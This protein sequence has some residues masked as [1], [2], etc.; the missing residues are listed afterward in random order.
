M[1]EINR[2]T[3]KN[4]CVDCNDP[5]CLLAGDAEADCPKWRCDNPTMDC[6]NCEDLKEYKEWMT[7]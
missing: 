3:R 2:C 6:E 1:V 5:D 4:L 7:E